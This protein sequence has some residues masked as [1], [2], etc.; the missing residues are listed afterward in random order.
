MEM[1]KFLTILL[2]AGMVLGLSA[3]GSNKGE[4]SPYNFSIVNNLDTALNEVY[5]S[6]SEINDWG[7]NILGT[8]VLEKGKTLDVEFTGA[9][10]QSSV[11]DIAV[12]TPAGTE[13]QFKTID[14][15]TANVVNLEMQDGAAVASIQ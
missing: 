11:F 14:L 4:E 8:S 3:C 2:S 7:E 5:I 1:K 13:Y 10:S 12:I 6:S 9:A 15:N